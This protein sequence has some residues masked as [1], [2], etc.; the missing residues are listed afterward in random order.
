MGPTP[1]SGA[2]PR[3]FLE[4]RSE[5]AAPLP[6]IDLAGEERAQEEQS[7]GSALQVAVGGGSITTR[8]GC[9]GSA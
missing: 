5:I 7:L 9:A 3:M 2:R 8:P 1:S 6:A 4:P